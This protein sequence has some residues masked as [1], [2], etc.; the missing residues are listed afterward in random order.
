MGVG[1]SPVPSNDCVG[2]NRAAILSGIV[3]VSVAEECGEK[4][5]DIAWGVK[6]LREGAP[7][8]HE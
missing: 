8:A 4:R 3:A 2:G 5:K 7:Q 1:D 6:T